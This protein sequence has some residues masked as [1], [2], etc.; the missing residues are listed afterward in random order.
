MPFTIEDAKFG[1]IGLF[2]SEK[3]PA[4]WLPCDG[5]ILPVAE[6]QALFSLL[7]ATYGGDGSTTFALP[8]LRGRVP[9]H[10][11]PN[12]SRN[13]ICKLGAVL[14]EAT[15]LLTT[16]ELPAHN[17]KLYGSANTGTTNS[18]VDSLLATAPDKVYGNTAADSILKSST[19][20]AG[21]QPQPHQNMQPYLTL[22]FCISNQ[23][24][25]PM[26]N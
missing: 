18:P 19:V 2:P 22:C 4:G 21:A 26:R 14:G 3:I 9:I 11:N 24:V 8:D 25:Y 20:E 10:Q 7:G 6:N 17:H 15:H 13:P 16:Q 1:E 12:D 23:G 5:Q